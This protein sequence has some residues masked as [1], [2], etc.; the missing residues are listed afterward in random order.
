MNYKRY[1][2][3]LLSYAAF[4]NGMVKAGLAGDDL[5]EG[6]ED[7]MW[8][9]ICDWGRNLPWLWGF[10]VGDSWRMWDDINTSSGVAN[11]DNGF[12][13]NIIYEYD[14]NVI[15]DE[16]AGLDKGW[17]DPDML[18]VG[19]REGT[20]PPA[21][22]AGPNGRFH[23]I[24][25]T[26]HFTTWCMMNC[27]LSLG[28]DLR[29][30]EVGDDV[31]QVIT[32]KEVVDLTQDPLGIQAKR[33]KSIGNGNDTTT[34]RNPATLLTGARMDVLAKPLADGSIAIT[35]FNTGSSNNA[36]SRQTTVSVDEIINGNAAWAG[37]MNGIGSKMADGNGQA[38]KNA[39]KYLVKNLWTKEVS[40]ND[41]GVFDSGTLI[42]RESKTIKVTPIDRNALGSVVAEAEELLASKAINPI[43]SANAALAA[44]IA[45][46]KEVYNLAAATD[47]QIA[48]AVVALS[49]A[50]TQFKADYQEQ[51][52]LENRIKEAVQELGKE[53]NA[54]LIASRISARAAAEVL[55]AAIAEAK[56][57]LND[58]TKTSVDLL[59]AN[60]VLLAA[61]NAFKEALK[62]LG[63]GAYAGT[64]R[65]KYPLESK[66]RHNSP[67]SM[68]LTTDI[69]DFYDVTDSNRSS[70]EPKNLH[71]MALDNQ[72]NNG[73]I[74]ISVKVTMSP[75]ANYDT[76]TLIMYLDDAP[77]AGFQHDNV[78]HAAMRR[79]H[80]GG[81]PNQAFFC[82]HRQGTGAATETRYT[83]RAATAQTFYLRVVKNPTGASDTTSRA[84]IVSYFRENLTEDWIEIA[85]ST[86]RTALRDAATIHV[87]VQ[88]ASGNTTAN[89]PA[90]FEDFTVKLGSGTPVVM[91]FTTDS[92][93][94]V[95]EITRNIKSGENPDFPAKVNA[96]WTLG[97]VEAFDVVW[98]DAGIDFNVPGNYV[99]EG[100][101]KDI[102]YITYAR[103]NVEA[104]SLS[105]GMNGNDVEAKYV[106][107]SME[108]GIK[109]LLILAYYDRFS[110]VLSDYV[111]KVGTMDAGS[112][113]AYD[114]L[115]MTVPP[116]YPVKAFVWNADTFVPLHVNGEFVEDLG[117][118]AAIA[119]AK[120][121]KPHNDHTRLSVDR[122]QA[123]IQEAEVMANRPATREEILEMVN[124]L[125]TPLQ[126]RYLSGTTF[127][128]AGSYGN[129]GATF[130]MIF[131]GEVDTFFDAP[132]STAYA[133]FDL[134]AGNASNV[135]YIRY[136]PRIETET[137][138][139]DIVNRLRGATI[140]GSN[141]APTSSNAG[142]TGTVL[143][144]VPTT[145][146][147]ALGGA[148]YTVTPSNTTATY[149]YFWIYNTNW[150]GN[151]AELQFWVT[152]P[153]YADMTLLNDRI[154]YAD[155][156][157][158][159]NFTPTSWS[160]MQA[161]LTA[162]KAISET[163]AQSAVDS[164]A[165]NLKIAI[166]D[167]V[168]N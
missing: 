103:V 50:S 144:T 140:R 37:R 31:W 118:S 25:D 165:Q 152:N 58:P 54:T 154:A 60:T 80:N 106:V 94:S 104:P 35:F 131:D 125:K 156:L 161:A 90:T 116:G 127:G 26:S 38:F 9:K 85:R 159:S 32:N 66:V 39:G 70:K 108:P 40:L 62:A 95:E 162:A 136:F 71:I 149:R 2:M 86:N 148:W 57:A 20:T 155:S 41:T 129:S 4:Y 107:F 114:S 48:G 143:H 167:L 28:N 99:V 133:G 27:P 43:N 93:K 142:S 97:N 52:N 102:D 160:A 139:Q 88:A 121:I 78:F 111:S 100:I 96:T 147:L 59:S 1:E 21:G 79:F 157:S 36:T 112:R 14:R 101:V 44:G 3:G 33:I 168:A 10:K 145:G 110:G 153:D 115:K 91:P 6:M 47:E 105:I 146:N 123:Y 81:T 76:A 135:N 89:R 45:N 29:T 83:G 68:T 158:A 109:Y 34:V 73:Q 15:L 141:T 69:G 30:V 7:E 92:I 130:D 67:T 122:L 56:A 49:A 84:T 65:N 164:A 132:D 98:K 166:A 51:A 77:A 120:A 18:V 128:T 64:W 124:K 12:K 23:K 72:I 87:G 19:L 117:L 46:A 74:D 53:E 126:K 138:R 82:Q 134:G 17:N 119:E 13:F 11:W 24:S 150:W 75:S 63:Q 16:Y 137:S 61:L 5:N 113:Y 55:E 42:T 151:V 22:L 8:L 163:S